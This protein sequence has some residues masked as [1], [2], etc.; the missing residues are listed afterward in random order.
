MPTQKRNKGFTIIETLVAVAIL[1][2]SIAGPLTI[3]HK[4]L[5]AA[6]N[7]RD[8]VTASY[9]AQ[10]AMEYVKNMRDNNKLENHSWL[11]GFDGCNS[12]NACGVNTLNE[13]NDAIVSDCGTCVLKKDNTG[14]NHSTGN[15]SQFSR[16]FYLDNIN[17]G[18][19][20]MVVEVKWN[21]GTIGNV[22]TYESEIFDVLK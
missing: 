16:I 11:A 4:G 13:A 7:A 18:Q 14:Y 20:T 19:A 2:I 22:V 1:M 12:V 17:I 6:I 8:Q 15:N 9:L 5:L 21:S 10:D 3:A